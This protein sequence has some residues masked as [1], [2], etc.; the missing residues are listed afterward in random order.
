MNEPDVNRP[1]QV[2]WG[3]H[4]GLFSS[5]PQSD[6]LRVFSR[7]AFLER[8]P[9]KAAYIERP[10][11]PDELKIGDLPVP[12]IGDDHVLIRVAYSA[13]NPID[14]YVRG[15]VVAMELPDRFC[16]GCDASGTV[17]AI[18]KNVK[19]IQVGDRVWTTN[20]GLLGR[21]GTL[22][23]QIAVDEKWV[24]ELPGEVSLRDAAANAL[25]GVTAHLGLF[26]EAQLQPGESVLVIGGTGGVGAMVVQMAIAAGA[27]VIATAGS[28]EKADCIKS[29]GADEVIEY[30]NESIAARTKAFESSGV[31]V[32]WET[33][34]EPDF[35]LAI[36]LMAERGR[37][38]LMAGRDATPPLPVGPF[39]V[40]ECS[41]HGF[42]MFKASSLEMRGAA[43]DISRWMAQGKLRS[44]IGAEFSLIDA[45]KA[46]RLQESATLGDS[47]TLAGKIVVAIGGES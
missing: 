20:Q 33:R 31:N 19:R 6:F 18:G 9:V 29:W 8:V 32:F 2:E 28:C 17:E 4:V 43:E 22:A 3:H 46:H 36:D 15:G 30:H 14:T 41:L 47:K 44:N 35:E 12:K 26:R 38:V 7:K 34:R 24:F 13:V 5:V 42:V 10:G 1:K 39:Y 25:V 23:E 45:A 37:M 27:R 11:S 16:P 40:K 21:Q